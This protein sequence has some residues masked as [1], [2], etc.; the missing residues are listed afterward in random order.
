MGDIIVGLV[1]ASGAGKS[2]IAK[3]LVEEFNF[4]KLHIGTPLKAMLMA[5]GLSEYD[6][7]GPPEHRSA[8]NDVL[9]GKSVRFALSTLGTEW[10]RETIGENLWSKSLERRIV[11]RLRENTRPC[12][13]VVDDLRYPSDWDVIA[14]LGGYIVTVRR[15]SVEVAR[16]PLDILAYRYGVRHVLPKRV[17]SKFLT[18]ES[19]YHWRDAPKA[20][21]VKNTSNPKNSAEA[22]V[23]ELGLRQDAAS[24]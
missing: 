3:T 18:H 15:P 17:L 2:T 21:E 16:S 5:L 12:S 24:T 23:R 4:T 6:V 13:I 20:F 8:P 7:A 22:L 19:E 9:S 1:G 11:E 14:S 10:G